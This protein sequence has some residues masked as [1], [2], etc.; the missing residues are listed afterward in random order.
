MI[1]L[2]D[3]AEKAGVS[4]MTVSRVV[5]GNTSKVSKATAKRIQKILDEEGYVPNFSA[6]SL[7]SKRTNII[8]IILRKDSK[9]DDPY[10][11][12]MLASII[13]YLQENGF[14]SMVVCIDEFEEVNQ[15]LK[16][17]HATGAIFIGL[18]EHDIEKI[19][20]G[21]AIPL[22]F[23]DS[24]QETLNISNVG[25]DDYKGGQLAAKHL[26]DNHHKIMAFATYALDN[27]PVSKARHKGFVDILNQNQLTLT[28]DLIYN[29]HSAEHVVEKL[30][31]SKATALFATT[32]ILA[33][34]IIT[35]LKRKGYAVPQDYSVI[36]FDNLPHGEFACPQLTTIGQDI[37][38]K[39]K[40]A[41][42]MLIQSL[43]RK[44][45]NRRQVMDVFLVNRQSVKSI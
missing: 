13:P 45:L 24:Y 29:D 16:A 28:E 1:R 30:I 3:I 20:K 19:K 34:N 15:Y 38:A 11:A 33:L 35:E 36:G 40:A 25:I 27:S 18:F 7:I 17:W 31:K 26:I 2:K 32:D 14:F 6:R 41:C 22:I 9:P 8:A 12:S 23:T 21:H 4:T 10:N 5:N 44:L 43:D 37:D 39:G 42:E